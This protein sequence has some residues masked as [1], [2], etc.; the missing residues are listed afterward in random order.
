MHF[1]K[2]LDTVTI[3]VADLLL[4][5]LLPRQVRT[6]RWV[7]IPLWRVLWPSPSLGSADLRLVDDR[8]LFRTWSCS[9]CY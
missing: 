6:F 3:P 2:K 9:S 5:C 4:R 7:V 1:E 8:L